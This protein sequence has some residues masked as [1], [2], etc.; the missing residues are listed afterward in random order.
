MIRRLLILVRKDFRSFLTDPVAI[1]L[2]L[3]V[4][5]VMILV[6]GI[7]FGGMGGGGLHEFYV[8]AVNE[9]SGPAGRR[10]LDALDKLDEIVIVE[11]LRGDT[12]ALD[13]ARARQRVA[14]G[15]NSVALIVP[16]DFSEGLK[17]GEV[18]LTLLEDPKEK[19]AAGVV[20]GLL[21]REVFSTFPALLPMNLS[22]M[23]GDREDSL[24]WKAF[25]SSI[26]QLVQQH[27]HVSF[28]DTWSS[29]QMFPEEMILG[30]NLDSTKTG[31][32]GPNF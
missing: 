15:K 8:L 1:G 10:L 31:T 5:M 32:S 30:G 26:R 18:R 11:R 17:A 12:L 16:S 6:F 7:V 24:Q 2:S 14:A 29:W 9:D 20:S 23:G 27:F 25:N 4:P 22:Q 13:S 28:P 3:V 21:Q 19:V